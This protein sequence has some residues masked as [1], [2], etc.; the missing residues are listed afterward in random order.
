[1]PLAQ[2]QII[3]KISEMLQC[4]TTRR[5]AALTLRTSL[6]L[7]PTAWTATSTSPGPKA[8]LAASTDTASGT[9]APRLPLGLGRS[10]NHSPEETSGDGPTAA[11]PALESG[12]RRGTVM[13]EPEAMRELSRCPLTLIKE[14]PWPD[15]SGLPPP[16]PPPMNAP[17]RGR[18]KD[19]VSEELGGLLH[20]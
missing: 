2:T 15:G 20:S 12:T 17:S 11:P 8:A 19:R 3:K 1:M 13:T 10:W 7:I 4:G 9:K 6:K 5:I 14:P 16:V 18:G